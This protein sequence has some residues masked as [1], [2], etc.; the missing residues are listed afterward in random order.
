MNKLVQEAAERELDRAILA[1]EQA[2]AHYYRI[3]R[4]FL[5]T[6][7]AF[8]EEN[9]CKPDARLDAGGLKLIDAAW[10]TLQYTEKKLRSAYMKLYVACL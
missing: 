10:L 5:T 2:N 4:R 1:D 8:S 7:S 9:P 3:L 6:K